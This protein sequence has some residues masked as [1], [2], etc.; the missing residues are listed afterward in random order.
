MA[1]TYTQGHSHSST[2]NVKFSRSETVLSNSCLP[3]SIGSATSCGS[4]SPPPSPLSPSPLPSYTLFLSPAFTCAHSQSVTSASTAFAS[5]ST[6]STA[7]V[8]QA[9]RLV[10]TAKPMLSFPSAGRLTEG[11]L[12][13]PTCPLTVPY[14]LLLLL[15]LLLTDGAAAAQIDRVTVTL[16]EEAKRSFRIWASNSIVCCRI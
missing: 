3:A 12:L 7:S 1:R 13:W 11:A 16:T 15:L 8:L 14:A 9:G 2:A 5:T 6:G 4:A 10:T